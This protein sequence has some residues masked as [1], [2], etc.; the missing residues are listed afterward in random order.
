MGNKEARGLLVRDRNKIVAISAVSSPKMTVQEITTISKSRNVS[1]E[2]LRVIT[3]N[4]EWTR[5]YQVKLG[6]ATNPKCPISEAIKFV[7]YL[8]DRELRGMMRSKDV[9]TVISTHA[10]RLLMKRGKI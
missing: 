2:V 9:P 8:Q 3:R 6:L 7:N 1:D 4:R 5:N 10:R